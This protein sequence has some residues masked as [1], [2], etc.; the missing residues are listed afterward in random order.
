MLCKRYNIDVSNYDFTDIPSE[1]QFKD[2]GTDIRKELD[3]IRL[4]YNS[5]NDRIQERFEKGFNSEK[6]RSTKVQER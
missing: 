3:T 4:A 6:N 5:I 1:L 2:N